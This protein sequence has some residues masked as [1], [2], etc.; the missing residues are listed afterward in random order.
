VER[1][2]V[3]S[4]VFKGGLRRGLL[5]FIR[6][7]IIFRHSPAWPIGEKAGVRGNG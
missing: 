6:L 3:F 5:G 2:V 7:R 1:V 4:F